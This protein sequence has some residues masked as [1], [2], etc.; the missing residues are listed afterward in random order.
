MDFVSDQL[1]N[2]RRFRVQNIVD[3]YSREIVLQIVDFSISGYR[4]VRELDQLER[5]LPKSIVCDNGPEFTCKAM[6]LWAKKAG[7]KLHFIQ[8]DKT[9]RDAF[10]G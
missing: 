6:F 7:T 2:G 4:V 8:P 10:V 9:T 3:D 1:G 5:K